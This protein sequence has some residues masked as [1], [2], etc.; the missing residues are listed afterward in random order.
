MTANETIR[1]A[2]IRHQVGVIRAS[3]TLSRQIIAL[4]NR[5]EKEL[6]EKIDKR[7]AQIKE[8]G[9]D[10]GPGT[11]KRL[12]ALEDEIRAILEK[13]QREITEEINVFLEGVATREPV[14]LKTV[15]AE[16][17]PVVVSMNLPAAKQLRDIVRFK[18]IDGRLLGDWVDGMHASDIRRM[19]EEIRRGLVQGESNEQIA[20]RIFGSRGAG[21]ARKVTR[22]EA[23]IIAR[24]A[25]NSVSNMSRQTFLQANA[26][27][28]KAE[29][30]VA[31]LDSATCPQCGALDGRRWEVGKGPIPPA[32][33]QCR[34]TKVAAVDDELIG[35][36]PFKKS[37]ERELLGEY[38]DE[39]GIDAPKTRGALPRGHKGKFDAFARKRGRELVGQV[40]ASTTYEEFM[41][42]Q[43]RAFQED[44]LGKARA[45]A[46]RNGEVDLGDFVDDSGRMYTLDELMKREPDVFKP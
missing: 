5:T 38:A 13:P 33:P 7:L 43:T 32:H 25:T 9:V 18:P 16:E 3:G 36:R 23:E 45:K 44:V 19:N 22:R 12:L 20:R 14:F 8:R 1:D 15:I 21:G 37:T 6:R 11:T 46:W 17:L 27:V 2:L 42:K 39:A 10:F 34:C 29:V 26:D 40:P 35:N 31:T 41:R 24:T 30:W 28:I 4:L